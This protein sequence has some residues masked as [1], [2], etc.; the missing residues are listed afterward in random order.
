MTQMKFDETD[1]RAVID[2][3]SRHFGVR[4]EPVG[5]RRKWLRDN[6][7]RS[8]WVLG[9]YGEW[10]G[11]PEEMMDAEVSRPSGGFFVIAMRHRSTM[12]IF[13]SPLVPLVAARAKLNR[14]SQTTG[15]YQF[16]FKKRGTHLIID[17]IPNATLSELTGFSFDKT[18]KD[19]LARFRKAEKLVGA[20]SEDELKKLQ[21]ELKKLQDNL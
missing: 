12:E 7:A 4:I 2:A 10:H 1:R 9:G 16:T 13:I 5:R 8:Y 18:E 21:D 15:D 17:Q 14:A 19:S 11:I 3:L 20:L 6:A